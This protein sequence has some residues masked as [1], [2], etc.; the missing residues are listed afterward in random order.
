MNGYFTQSE[1]VFM[2]IHKLLTYLKSFN[3]MYF[4]QYESKQSIYI[5]NVIYF[6]MMY[7][8]I[9]VY[10]QFMKTE[11]M[12][13]Y[14]ASTT[15]SDESRIARLFQF[16]AK[17]LNNIFSKMINYNRAI[18][19]FL[20]YKFPDCPC[21]YNI[22]FKDFIDESI[23][24]KERLN[25]IPMMK[26]E[27]VEQLSTDDIEQFNSISSSIRCLYELNDRNG[28][29]NGY[30]LMDWISIP[31]LMKRND[32]EKIIERLK[33]LENVGRFRYMMLR[34]AKFSTRHKRSNRMFGFFE[35]DEWVEN[36]INSTLMNVLKKNDLNKLK[37]YNKHIPF[38]FL[39]YSFPLIIPLIRTKGVYYIG[40]EIE[41]DFAIA[42]HVRTYSKYSF[43]T[44]YTTDSDLLVLLSD[45]DCVVK[46][47]CSNSK[48]P[49]LINPVKFWHSIFNCDLSPKII[50][51]LCVL[52]GTDYNPFS[53]ESPIHIK[54][55][56]QI[57]KFLNIANYSD[58]DEDVLL[59]KLYVKMN[60]NKNNINVKQ[61]AFA[62]NMYLN[63]I[64]NN[65]HY[66]NNIEKDSIN[67]KQFLNLFRSSW[68]LA[69]KEDS[70]NFN[71]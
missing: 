23:H 26:R 59:T 6:D 29:L 12:N 16:V 22:L 51:I 15:E 57:L 32:D 45:I 54:N 20:D 11:E 18:Y 40:C 3:D 5:S 34:G 19:A 66:I 21:N 1:I 69:I 44:I 4:P 41:S 9:D 13:N 42:K 10:N 8:L 67:V 27:Y 30:D 2:G 58:I 47:N 52:L 38:S 64:E 14:G 49:Y 7:K 46:M 36:N 68:F 65:L 60:E 31:C 39:L 17:E 28:K 70:S 53:S 71:H 62:L 37:K 50:K 63:D 55:F 24:V 25:C 35:H 56:K 48:K 43:P 33:Y 61:T